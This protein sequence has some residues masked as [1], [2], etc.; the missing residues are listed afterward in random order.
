MRLVVLV[1]FLGAHFA[2]GERPQKP[3]SNCSGIG[4]GELLITE[5]MPNP[6]GSDEGQEWFEIYNASSRTLFLDDL[7][8]TASKPDL[9]QMKRMQVYEFEI[10]PKQ[11]V[12]FGG[13]LKAVAPD[14]VDYAY[15]NSLSS[16]PNS[17][18]GR[19]A[20]YC[21]DVLVDEFFYPPWDKNEGKS[22]ILDGS[23][24]PEEWAQDSPDQR[25]YCASLQSYDGTNMGSPKQR[26]EP[27]KEAMPEG[28]CF[29]GNEVRAQQRPQVGDVIITEI[30]A[31]P[32][33]VSYTKGE[34]I[35]LY[36]GKDLDLNCLQ[37][38]KAGEEG[39]YLFDSASCE[40]FEKGSFIVLARSTNPEEN[41][42]VQADAKLPFSLT[43]S[44]MTLSVLCD[45]EEIDSVTY[46]GNA[47]SESGVSWQLDPAHFDASS[48]DD[49]SNWCKS[50]T[51]F[52]SG[53]LGTPKNANEPCM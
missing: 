14:F 53:D 17:S 27:C 8:I 40:R 6:S 26:N 28:S 11:Y 45:G 12:V 2:C 36:I 15:A 46:S 23:K 49:P 41:G 30:H 20:I 47:F 42:G 1:F 31:R 10:P 51:K 16:L 44:G 13:M 22:V 19:L 39:Q 4:Q 32:K 48:N 37:V 33:A 38:A 3:G 24:A 5:V 21:G 50:K 43:D 25:V 34:W 9:S 29:D 18:G 35:E 7:T 52:G